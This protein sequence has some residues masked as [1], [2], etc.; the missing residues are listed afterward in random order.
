MMLMM[1]QL[2]FITTRFELAIF[3]GSYF[4][5][6]LNSHGIVLLL[7]GGA[8]VGAGIVTLRN[9][10]VAYVDLITTFQALQAF[11]NFTAL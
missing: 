4:R 9:N 11:S 1:L 2:L 8:G 10:T 6:F 3:R 7:S 5:N